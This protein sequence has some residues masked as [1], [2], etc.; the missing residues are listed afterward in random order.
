MINISTQRLSLRTV[1]Q[2]DLD[3]VAAIWGDAEAAKYMPDPCYQ[4]GADI[5]EILVDDPECPCYYFAAFRQGFDVVIGT[6]SLGL[7]NAKSSEFSIGY[8][9]RKD[10]W[11]N[12]YA[13]E[14]VY[15]LIDFART[16]GI[17][18]ITAPV[19]KENRASNRVLEKCGFVIVG[20]S[21]FRKSGTDIV[22]PAFIYR[23]EL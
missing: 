14:M 13:G 6:C 4:S 21:S 9:V 22:H 16:L 11:G 15:A 2:E 23:L 7:E 1:L 12:G 5:A 10:L 17:K 3:A 20:D 19:A 8:N 18:A